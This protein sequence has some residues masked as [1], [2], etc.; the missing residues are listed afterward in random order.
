[1]GKIKVVVFFYLSS[2][3]FMMFLRVSVQAL[4]VVR[5]SLIL[6][7]IFNFFPF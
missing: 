2:D 7:V 6:N 3:N 1:M 5:L 4:P